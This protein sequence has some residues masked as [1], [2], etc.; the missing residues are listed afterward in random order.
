MTAMALPRTLRLNELVK[1][2]LSVIIQREYPITQMGLVTLSRVIVSKDLQHARV[3]FTA[4][5][6]REK[7]QRVLKRLRHD[8]PHLR[9]LLA[10]E[11]RLRYTPELIFAIDEELEEA[12]RVDS[13]IEKVCPHE[14]P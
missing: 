11:I 3:F 5:G 1:R 14:T 12:I 7:E 13:L 4:L 9:Y 8:Q 2:K 6:G 10:H